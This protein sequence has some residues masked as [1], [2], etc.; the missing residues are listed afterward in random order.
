MNKSKRKKKRKEERNKKRSIVNYQLMIQK[1][2]TRPV[3]YSV[4][5]KQITERRMKSLLQSKSEPHQEE[6]PTFN[7]VEKLIVIVHWLVSFK[8]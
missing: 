3:L 8:F 4:M 5:I 1:M 6:D 7:S 2:Q